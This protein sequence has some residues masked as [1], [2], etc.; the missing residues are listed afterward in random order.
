[1]KKILCTQRRV[2]LLE[3]HGF[4]LKTPLPYRVYVE[5]I[6]LL[7]AEA[8]SEE[9]AEEDWRRMEKAMQEEGP[10]SSKGNS[11]S[12]A[13]PSTPNT[14]ASGS[15]SNVAAWSNERLTE[16]F[17]KFAASHLPPAYAY[18]SLSLSLL[19]LSLSLL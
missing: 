4:L 10:A 8:K 2:V 18:S 7:V 5:S 11:V 6:N 13:T 16:F 12:P 14:T 1:M 3:N 19:F 17:R 9:E 15:G